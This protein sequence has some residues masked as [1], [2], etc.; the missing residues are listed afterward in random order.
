MN[1][2]QRL[3]PADSSQVA[4]LLPPGALHV[5]ASEFNTIEERD[6]VVSMVDEQLRN[7]R[8]A[9]VE[10]AAVAVFKSAVG[11]II[12]L[13]PVHPTLPTAKTVMCW[14]L[15]L[16]DDSLYKHVGIRVLKWLRTKEAVLSVIGRHIQGRFADNSD[17]IE[18][19]TW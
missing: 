1:S 19:E 6:R 9:T 4:M 17:T 13:T 8:T 3:V 16:N 5:F 7:H 14:A 11:E 15:E 12:N 2:A 10:T 18:W